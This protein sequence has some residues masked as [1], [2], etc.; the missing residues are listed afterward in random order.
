MGYSQ[1]DIF[2]EFILY[3]LHGIASEKGRTLINNYFNF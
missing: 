3:H 1:E 2:K